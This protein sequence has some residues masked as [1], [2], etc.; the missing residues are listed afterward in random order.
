MVDVVV[1]NCS[2]AAPRVD[3]TMER[4]ADS[5]SALDQYE[6]EGPDRA[7]LFQDLGEFQLA[8]VRLSRTPTTWTM[9][10]HLYTTGAVQRDAGEQLQ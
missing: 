9:H 2:N 8:T 1:S 7:E 10:H 3:Q 5:D 4:A 6:I